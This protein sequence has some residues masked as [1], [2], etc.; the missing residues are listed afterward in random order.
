M[1]SIR[2]F[3]ILFLV[4]DFLA[5]NPNA[6]SVIKAAN[7]IKGHVVRTPLLETPLLNALVCE[8]LGVKDLRVK[9]KAECLQHTG[10]F[11]FRG[12]LNRVMQLTEE[13]REKGVVAF[14]SGN[15]AQALALAA[16]RNGVACTIVAPHDAPPLKLSR[17]EKYGAKV[18]LSTPAPG[19]NREVAASALAQQ[20]A[21][22]TGA[23]LL[24]PFDD[25]PVI[26]GQGTLAAEVFEQMDEGEELAALVVPTGGGGM[27][28]GCAL[29]AELF[30]PATKLYT[31]EPERYD[32]HALSLAA[33]A[34]TPLSGPPGSTVCDALQ[35][36]APGKL[37]WQVNG[38]RLAGATTMPDSAAIEGM[39]MA[40]TELK[41]VLEPSGALG[42]AALL[43]GKIDV[44]SGDSV[45]VVACGGNV[46]LEDYVKMVG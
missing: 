14:S 35:A 17:T 34:H 36:S 12:S 30:S 4:R 45:C 29:A 15:F 20:F 26:Y 2:I 18:V 31:V 24:H 42:L 11:K 21:K 13:E 44:K 6:K 37:T 43:G 10:A 5:M 9:V 33:G 32:D 41:L 3:I 27:M 46:Q 1:I 39:K 16:T 7:A 40:F 38:S 25:W 23:T 28:A 19:E 22:E 8:R